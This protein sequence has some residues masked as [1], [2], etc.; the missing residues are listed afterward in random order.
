[1]ACVSPPVPAATTPRR[2][3]VRVL[4]V[5]QGV[6][7]RP[8]VYR[9]AS[10]LGLAGFV[11]NDARGVELEVEG[12]SDA[13]GRFL[14]L[15]EADAP[16]LASVDSVDAVDVAASGAVGF[17]ITA[18]VAG[19]PAALVT[20]DAATCEDCLGEVR[21]PGDRRFRYPLINCTN[22]GPRFTIVKGVPYDRPLTT[23][24]GFTMCGA[25]RA[26]YDDPGDRRFHAQPNACPAC[27][28]QVRLVDGRG[29]A[30]DAADGADGIAAAAA[31]LHAGSVV[32]IKG[33]G[34]YH[35]A[36]RADDADAVARLRTRKHREDKPFALMARDVAAARRLVV[37]DAQEEA[38]LSSPARPVVLAQRL[39]QAAV[40]PA[41]APGARELGVMLPYSPLHHLLL[42]D[43]GAPLVLTSGNVSDEPIAYRDADALERLDLIADAF[44]V[45]DRPIHMRTDDSVARV[46]RGRPMVLRRSRGFVPAPV[47]LPLAC[48]APILACGAELKSTFCLA[49]GS[50]AWLSHHIGDLGNAETLASFREGIAHFERLFDV[51]PEVVAHDLHP[52]YLSTSFALGREGVDPVAVQ[53]HHAHLA[54]CLAEHGVTEPA[55]GA[56][57]DGAGLGPDGTVWGGEI[58]VGDLRGFE[59]AGH[60]AT[61]RL[62]GGDRAAR[63]PWRM[64]C[65][66]LVAAGAGGSGVPARL[67][68]EVSG[69]RWE[70][71]ARLADTGFAAPE[72]TSMGRL[73]DAVA[74]LCGVRALATYEGH[75]AIELEALADPGEQGSY[76]FGADLDA[77]PLVLAIL[78][79]L[80]T[81]VAVPTISARFHRAV[82]TATADACAAAAS[83]AGLDL[84]ALSGGVFQNRLLLTLTAQRLDALGLRVL[85]PERL[86]V[87][88][89][90]VAYG[91]AAVAAAA[92]G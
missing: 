89:G 52:D 44:L 43:V 28:P 13:V 54:A 78:A 45:H 5:V 39:T 29:D 81:G 63:E 34:G 86:P 32:A 87:N 1:V 90:G 80:D 6:G 46:V 47:S 70:A 12:A 60:L 65:A 11:H 57:Y 85:V 2:V 42:A 31:L 14:D 18:S 24:A 62:P 23:M 25:C 3:R 53:H 88:D 50:R 20:P 37:L 30:A 79:D 75:A 51:I 10:E 61:V 41:V 22:C 69:D 8:F 66:W 55:V 17:T 77:R 92:G 9:L 16:P 76:A 49:Q 58:L 72:T 15:L 68:E 83:R 27:G 56:I 38:L 73:F 84:V 82:A 48:A 64:A 40:A 19:A 26:E 33:V 67:R 35:L 7:F 36:C 4:G 71:V 91:Q 74:A 21:D 59:R